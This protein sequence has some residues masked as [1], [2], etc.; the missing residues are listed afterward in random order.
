MFAG[1]ILSLLLTAGPGYP[2]PWR[3]QPHSEWV[4][5]TVI[6]KATGTRFFRVNPDGSTT[7][8]GVLTR[9]DYQVVREHDDRV[10]IKQ[11]GTEGWINKADVA[12]PEDGVAHFSKLIEMNPNDSAQFARRSK[13]N[14][15]KGDLDAALKDYDE[16]IRISPA[17]SSWWNNR[18]N[19]YQ[20]SKNYERA[21]EDYNKSIELNTGSAIV[22]G[23]RGNAHS[24]FRD[25]EK[26][27]ADYNEATRL[28]PQYTNSFVNRANVHREMGEY[29]KAE[30]DYDAALKIDPTFAFALGQRG[31]MWRIR[32]EYDKAAA[33]ITAAIRI[34]PRSA[35]SFLL[36]G[37][38][39]RSLKQYNLARDDYD[40]AIWLEPRL[41][42]AFVERGR[43]YREQKQY[44]KTLADYDVAL[45]QEP[46]SIMARLAKAELLA[47]CPE[48]R[49]RDGAKAVEL[50]KA[51]I[52][53]SRGPDGKALAVLAAAL[54]EKG[55]FDE[56]I[57]Q[58]QRA[59][60]SKPYLADTASGKERLESFKAKRPIRE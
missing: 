36:R 51:A 22:W 15:L 40:H 7:E 14:E 57:I 45:K 31:E 2:A 53:R 21:L 17:S 42:A 8:A 11:D 12:L 59:L 19:L 24:Y 37:N 28:N 49:I 23:N 27:I 10:L 52:E 44:D 1:S 39:R 43:M 60:E 48:D 13:S 16:A 30:A 33:D 26:A 34:D 18:A 56:A 25:Y 29:A 41:T 3:D 20:K 5:R 4:G 58:Q 9:T 32:R 35:Q 6:M 47:T 55:E 54:A 38:L 46:L 50:A